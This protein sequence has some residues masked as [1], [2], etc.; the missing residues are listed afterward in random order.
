MNSRQA[1]LQKCK[2]TDLEKD[3]TTKQTEGLRTDRAHMSRDA[4]T[5]LETEME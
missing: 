1:G 5:N 3:K 2:Q 4:V